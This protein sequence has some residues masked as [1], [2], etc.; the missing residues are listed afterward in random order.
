VIFSLSV[1]ANFTINTQLLFYSWYYNVNEYAF[2]TYLYT[3][4]LLPQKEYLVAH[5]SC[6][7]SRFLEPDSCAKDFTHPDV[8]CLAATLEVLAY[9]PKVFDPYE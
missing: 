5:D 7:W 2:V 9:V 4:A 6:G 3:H 1:H 8:D